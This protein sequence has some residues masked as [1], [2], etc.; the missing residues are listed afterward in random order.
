MI[1]YARLLKEIIGQKEYHLA[2][3]D[4]KLYTFEIINS[5]EKKY[6]TVFYNDYDFFLDDKRAFS[7]IE[8]YLLHIRNKINE[9]NN[10]RY[11]KD[12]TFALKQIIK[13]LPKNNENYNKFLL[14]IENRT[15]V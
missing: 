2:C 13:N 5:F 4:P 3:L 7:L 11:H 14:N 12:I 10:L 15:N 6:E 9:E 1:E 8:N